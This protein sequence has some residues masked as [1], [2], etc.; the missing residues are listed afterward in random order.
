MKNFNVLHPSYTYDIIRAYKQNVPTGKKIIMG[1][2]GFKFVA[3]EDSLLQQENLRRA[4]GPPMLLWMTPRCLFTTP[5]M[6]QT[7]LMR[8]SKQSMPDIPAQ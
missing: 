7:W 2:I 6:A 3:P 1:E 4:K 5:C 8:L